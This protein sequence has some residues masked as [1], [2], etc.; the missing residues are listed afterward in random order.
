MRVGSLVRIVLPVSW[1]RL[2]TFAFMS[3]SIRPDRRHGWD[4]YYDVLLLRVMRDN[5][6]VSVQV[7]AEEMVLRTDGCIKLPNERLDAWLVGAER[8]RLVERRPDRPNEWGTTSRGE[9]RLRAV[10]PSAVVSLIA[11]TVT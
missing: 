5:G 7:L 6:W 11:L 10:K 9:R 3:D 8:R 2:R 4:P 1:L